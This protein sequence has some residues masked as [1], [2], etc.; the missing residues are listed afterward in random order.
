MKKFIVTEEFG[1]FVMGS[2]GPAIIV[3]ENAVLE[4]QETKD[5]NDD[6]IYVFEYNGETVWNYSYSIEDLIKEVE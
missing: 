5:D 4:I 3:R 1:A 6:F 2:E